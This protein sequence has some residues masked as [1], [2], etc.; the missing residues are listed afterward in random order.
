I[1]DKDGEKK[2]DD[3][4]DRTEMVNEIN[5]VNDVFPVFFKNNIP[6][7]VVNQEKKFLGCVSR[8]NILKVCGNH[9]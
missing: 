8:K 3:F 2:I 7:P 9:D 5:T 6:L 4:L 1:S